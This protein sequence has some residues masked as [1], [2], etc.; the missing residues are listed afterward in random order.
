MTGVNWLAWFQGVFGFGSSG[1]M[2]FARLIA[3]E[4]IGVRGCAVA[5]DAVVGAGGVTGRAGSPSYRNAIAVG[6]VGKCFVGLPGV[7]GG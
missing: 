4:I 5:E 2:S 3:L 6:V 1:D 7:V